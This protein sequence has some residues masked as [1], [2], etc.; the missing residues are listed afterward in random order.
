MYQEVAVRNGIQ[1]LDEK[2]PGW[3]GKFNGE[4]LSTYDNETCVLGQ[5]FGEYETGLREL[6]IW[7]EESKDGGVGYGFNIPNWRLALA[8]IPSKYYKLHEQL[9]ETWKVLVTE[10]ILPTVGLIEVEPNSEPKLI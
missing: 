3:R 1:L 2:L 10:T 7:D 9:T 6:G 4:T 8:I 5:Q